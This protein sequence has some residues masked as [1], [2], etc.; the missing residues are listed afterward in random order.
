[1]SQLTHLQPMPE[2]RQS[3]IGW[4]RGRRQGRSLE[5]IRRP[6]PTEGWRGV[7]DFGVRFLGLNLPSP[8]PTA[9]PPTPPHQRPSPAG[10][11]EFSFFVAFNFGFEF[12][13][14]FTPLP[15]LPKPPKIAQ[16]TSKNLPKTPQNHFQTA[17][18]LAM[19][20]ISKKYDPPIRNPHF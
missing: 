15:N 7:L 18:H 8:R 10:F 17:S 4:L 2:N 9:M 19:P 14:F 3:S 6:L 16:K 20:E 13:L 5:N 12:L 11:A 1:M